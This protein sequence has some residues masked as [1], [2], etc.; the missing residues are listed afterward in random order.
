[1]VLTCSGVCG[2]EDLKAAK[3]DEGGR[4]P[5]DDRAALLLWVACVEHV[6]SDSAVRCYDRPGPGA[7]DPL[8][9]QKHA[10]RYT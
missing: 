9:I 3:P 10:W 2:L 8:H 7:G 4:Y 5:Q 6:T 1:M